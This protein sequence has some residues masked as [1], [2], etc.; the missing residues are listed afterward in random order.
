MV[1][2]FFLLGVSQENIQLISRIEDKEARDILI[3]EKNKALPKGTFFQDVFSKYLNIK[4]SDPLD[5]T[6]RLKS[7]LKKME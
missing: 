1:N 6:K 5:V 2:D 7:R 4:N 3:M